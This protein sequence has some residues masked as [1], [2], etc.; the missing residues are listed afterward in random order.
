MYKITLSVGKIT[1]YHGTNTKLK[2]S[3]I[4][5]N[6]PN[7][8]DGNWFSYNYDQA[9]LHIL[10]KYKEIY[11]YDYP[12]ALYGCP[13]NIYPRVYSYY[14]KKPIELLVLTEDTY[15]NIYHQYLQKHQKPLLEK[16][17]I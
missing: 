14:I 5:S 16:I 17:F 10:Q 8:P 11:L 6:M 12:K 1:L 7:N 3:K 4:T 2:R 9:L 13:S 15:S